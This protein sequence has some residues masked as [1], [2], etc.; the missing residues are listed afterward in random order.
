MNTFYVP[1]RKASL[2]LPEMQKYLKDVP[3]GMAGV[4][5][6]KIGDM[7]PRSSAWYRCRIMLRSAMEKIISTVEKQKDISK[8]RP[9]VQENLKEASARMN[10]ELSKY[11]L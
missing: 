10:K 9:M 7:E 4:E 5:Q 6:L 8:I 3:G 2:G 11:S 1:T